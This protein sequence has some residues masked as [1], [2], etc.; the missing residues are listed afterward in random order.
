VGARVPWPG[1]CRPSPVAQLVPLLVRKVTLAKWQNTAELAE[2][3]IPADAAVDL[4]T[5]GNCLS[6]W[7]VESE[8]ELLDAAL[9]M[10][11]GVERIDRIQIAWVDELQVSGSGLTLAASEGRTPVTDLRDRHVDVTHL[12]FAR[13]GVFARLVFDALSAANQRTLTR[14]QVQELIAEAIRI[15]RLSV[16]DL[17]EKIRPAF[18]AG[19]TSG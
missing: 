1:D 19:D 14:R 18:V 2:A 7:R 15:G 5:E 8:A 16:N 11:A 10:A 17:N 3:E 4:R 6:V 13:L 12:D 9:A